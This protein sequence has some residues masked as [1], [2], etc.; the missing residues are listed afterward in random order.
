MPAI[1]LAIKG[2]QLAGMIL[3]DAEEDPEG[4]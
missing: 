2:G 4:L 3:S 1:G